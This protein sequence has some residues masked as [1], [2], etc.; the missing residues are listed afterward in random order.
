VD[1]RCVKKISKADPPPRASS[2]SSSR[3]EPALDRLDVG[4]AVAIILSTMPRPLLRLLLLSAPVGGA[5]GYGTGGRRP[6]QAAAGRGRA[7]SSSGRPPPSARAAARPPSAS[8]SALD[9]GLRDLV[10][11]YDDASYFADSPYGSSPSVRDERNSRAYDRDSGFGS[12]GFASG[13]NS[14]AGVAQGAGGGGG[15]FAGGG[16]FGRRNSPG[17]VGFRGDDRG[18]GNYR[19]DD[20][21]NY[22]VRIDAPPP[23]IPIRGRGGAGGNNNRRP[24]IFDNVDYDDLPGSSTRR[25]NNFD[26]PR[27]GYDGPDPYDRGLDSDFINTNGVRRPTRSNVDRGVLGGPG[28]SRGDGRRRRYDDFDDGPPLPP[29]GYLPERRSFGARSFGR[30][31]GGGGRG[32][33]AG[34]A[35]PPQVY[36]RDYLD[37]LSGGRRDF[38]RLT[39]VERYFEAWNRRDVPLALSCFDDDVYYDDAQFGEPFDGK[40]A[41]AEHLLYVSDCLPDSYYVV[42]D[43]LSVGRSATSGYGR[44]RDRADV[45]TV[46]LG[47]SRVP[48]LAGR[49]RDPPT[50]GVGALWHVENEFGPLPF[51]RGCSFF[52]VDPNTDRIVEAYDFPEPAVVKTGSAGLR[53]LSLASKLTTEPKRWFPFFAWIAYVYIVYFSNGIL[54]GKDIFH[55]DPKTWR[56]V[57]ELTY[58]FLFLAPA[59]HLPTA[60]KLNPVLEGIFNGLLAWAFMF[61][62]FLS[63]E[64]SGMGPYGKDARYYQDVVRNRERLLDDGT[65]LV[66]PVS[67]T[68]K[69]LFGMVPAIVGMQFFLS[70][71]FLPYLFCRTAERSSFDFRRDGD[72]PDLPRR[73][74]PLYKEELDRPALAL[75]EWR[76]LGVLLGLFGIFALYW[77]F[78]GRPEDFGPPIWVS[79]KREVE[80]LKLLDK[81]R[82]AASFVVDLWVF[83]IFQ[84]WLVDDDW[85]RRGRSPDEEKFLRNVA[86]FVPFFGLASYLVFRPRYPSARDDVDFFDEEFYEEERFGEERGG[87]R[88]P[89]FGG[90]ARGRGGRGFF[91]RD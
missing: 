89:G 41:L 57:Q 12:G 61:A 62:G 4:V 50:V 85:R 2:S 88:L 23:P 75:G 44:R 29:G 58:N 60:A 43:E 64:R 54:P 49:G 87:F 47:R 21:P 20:Y 18:V 73:I 37:A 70:A 1:T 55:A 39:V 82:V 16:G 30:R 28:R 77:G 9:A 69:N 24:R 17:F 65:V 56:E 76:G 33:G 86:K 25:I 22:D 10:G 27:F 40:A 72:V 34:R 74:R 42:V 80:F 67:V 59:T 14:G 81:D 46:Q 26:G 53:V 66:P 90:R 3:L 5:V 71:F 78:A 35:P 91:D 51:A 45:P 52:K 63:D 7:A 38:D 31:G 32:G 8:S 13:G 83:G 84:G 19:N 68:K 15:G 36:R 11:P 48:Q 79:D 6:A